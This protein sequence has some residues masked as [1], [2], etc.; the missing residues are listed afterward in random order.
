MLAYNLMGPVGRGLLLG[1]GLAMALAAMKE[2]WELVDMLL[3]RFLFERE[4]R[5]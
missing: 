2:V 5:R 4:K 3:L 1:V